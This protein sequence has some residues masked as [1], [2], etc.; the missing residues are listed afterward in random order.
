[1]LPARWR[2]DVDRFDAALHAAWGA[3]DREEAILR[4]MIGRSPSEWAL[5]DETG[6]SWRRGRETDAATSTLAAA[7]LSGSPDG[8]AREAAV[9]A[10]AV[11]PHE[12]AAGF[13]LIR[14]DDWVRQVREPAQQAIRRLAE[15]GRL[16]PWF[17]LLLAR[18]GRA[19]AAA[20]LLP[21]LEATPTDLEPALLA[22]HDRATRRWA[23]ARVLDRPCSPDALERLLGPVRDAAVA[24]ALAA[25]LLGDEA[26][27]GRLRRDHRVSVRVEAWAALSRTA[28]L[29]L[30][31]LTQGLL[32]RSPMVRALAQTAARRRQIDATPLYLAAPTHAPAQRRRRLAGLA[33]WGAPE[34]WE[35]A[36]TALTDPDPAVRAT[37][38]GVLGPRLQTL[39]QLLLTTRGLELRAVI[40]AL[41]AQ[42]TFIPEASLTH[43]RQGAP[44]QRRAAWAVGRSQGIWHRLRAGL[45][46]M[47]DADPDLANLATSDVCAWLAQAW[48]H[49]G[50]PPPELRGV[51]ADALKTWPKGLEWQEQQLQFLMR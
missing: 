17:P 21:I 25:R 20:A 3:P 33:A 16:R 10:L 29:D 44:D 12:A 46:A 11:D 31:E 2:G 37:A 18:A 49:A 1:M 9:R 30:S 41:R 51:I 26:A 28:P 36:H 5:L 39:P 6:R 48:A 45:I 22:H 13:L 27:A 42:K 24:R 15:E 8:H 43:L 19:R 14:C 35:L 32:D 4:W 7:W 47:N 40:R 38:I 23:L 50:H 34:A